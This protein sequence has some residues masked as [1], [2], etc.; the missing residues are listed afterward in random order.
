MQDPTTTDEYRFFKELTQVPRPSGH[1]RRIRE[2]LRGFAVSHDLGFSEDEAGNIVIRRKG[3]TLTVVLQ[4]HMD[5]VANAEPGK[6][7]DFKNDP[8]VTSV[9]NGW[10]RA[11]GTTL[12]ADDGAG[13]ALILCALTDP[14]L[15]G[16]DIEGLFT[17]D[18]EIGLLGA[19]ALDSDMVT[20]RMLLNLDN[21]DIN[22]ITIGSAGSANITAEFGFSRSEDA[23]RFYVMEVGGLQGGHS[24]NDIDKNR[25]NAI[26]I[27]ARFLAKFNG[28]R[29]ASI[30]GGV[31]PNVIPTNAKAVFSVPKDFDAYEAFDDYCEHAALRYDEPDMVISLKECDASY[32][33]TAIKSKSFLEAL[34]MCPNGVIDTDVYGV[35]TSSNIGMIADNSKVVIMPRSSD[36]ERLEE[37]VDTICAL[38]RGRRAEAERPDA[39]PSWRESEDN[40]IVRT[41]VSVYREF[42]G[43]EPKLAV[44]HGG[45]EASTIKSKCPGMEAI[46]IGPTIIGAHS[47]EE[48]MDLSTLTQMKGYVFELIR[49][50][51]I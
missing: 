13:L 7:F 19:A 21:E 4:G 10:I 6:V 28:V 9:D 5:I 48:R 22:E 46:A 18:E 40:H 41:A 49:A 39:L 23:G 25:G 34:L 42:F 17:V 16:H 30:S 24:A 14:A 2:Y 1:L 38:F 27:V 36:N 44:T 35:R 26:L 47:P 11:D 8:L 3:N 31:A 51:S 45:L 43:R 15:D 33:W 50:L 20:G 12:G 29:I 32:S 37:L